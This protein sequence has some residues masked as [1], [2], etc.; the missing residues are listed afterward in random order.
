M[1]AAIITSLIAS[2]AAF[3]P[4]NSNNSNN[5]KLSE[6]KA[7]LEDIAGKL[8]P[9]V[10][11]WDPMGLSDGDFYDMGEEA[12]VGW[13]RHS[14]IKHGRVAMAAF[15]GY[16]V[17]S[18]FIFPWPQHLDGST[19]PSFDLSPEQQ[20]DAIPEAAKWQIFTLIG[21][22][23]IWDECSNLQGVPHY[24]KGRMPGQYPS[25]QPFRDNVHFALDLYDP[26]GF[27]KN[28]SEDA[29]ARG[30]LAEVNNGRLAM[31]G[32]FGFLSADK[33]AGSVP[34]LS[35]IAIPYDGNVMIPFEGNFHL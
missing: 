20:W 4:S 9:I 34:A 23:E 2:A 17:Q 27:S 16:C 19:G 35:E 32:I 13:L 26:F 12:T 11:F 25:L 14:E 29:K 21:F 30:R 10:K 7:D 33:V 15:V 8:N 24:T 28:R 18:N 5:V 6:T 3:A 1:K 22:L 31:L